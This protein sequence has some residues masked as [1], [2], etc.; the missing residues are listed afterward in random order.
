MDFYWADGGKG[1]K[2][3]RVLPVILGIACGNY[4][5]TAD[6]AFARYVQW[7]EILG[8]RGDLSFPLMLPLKHKLFQ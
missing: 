3:G 6:N 2:W 5:Q 4:L 7:V 1:V 8:I